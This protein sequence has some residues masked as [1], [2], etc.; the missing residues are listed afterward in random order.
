MAT[1]DIGDDSDFAARVEAHRRRR[2]A[3]WRTVEAG[4]GLIGALEALGPEAGAVV[5]D[6]L[7]TW[8]ATAPDFRVD[9]AR[10]CAALTARTGP[11][12][13]VSE[14]VGLGVHPSTDV[15]VRFRDALGVLNRSV[16]DVA[17]EVLLV[18]AGRALRLDRPVIAER[19]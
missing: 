1:A 6:S 18:V 4:P 19:A 13:V 10:L 16:A 11:T 17:G 2:P 5:V 15:G 14:E 8:V 12:V 7:G 3:G 9:G